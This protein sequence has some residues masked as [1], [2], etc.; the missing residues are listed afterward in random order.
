LLIMMWVE[1]YYMIYAAIGFSVLAVAVL[2]GGTSG[3][4]YFLVG[5]GNA[6]LRSM[7]KVVVAGDYG[8][9]VG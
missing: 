7:A 2:V 4:W 3:M 5:G 9:R 6:R 1:E 8:E